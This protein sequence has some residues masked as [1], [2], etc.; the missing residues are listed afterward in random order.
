MTPKHTRPTGSRISFLGVLGW[1]LPLLVAIAT[2]CWTFSSRQSDEVRR[3]ARARDEIR[4]IGAAL[5]APRDDGKPM[6]STAQGLLSLVDDGLLPHLPSDPW[7]HPYAYRNPGTIRTW[8]L[9]SLGPDG[10]ESADDIVSWNLYGG[11]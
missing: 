7:G 4:A 9:Y 2:G 10:V 11:R 6:P 8:E 5:I 3:V 1:L